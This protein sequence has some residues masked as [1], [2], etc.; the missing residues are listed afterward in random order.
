MSVQ[1]TRQPGPASYSQPDQSLV[2]PPPLNAG[3]RLS[4]AE[5]ERRHN[6]H[7]EI[8]KAELVEGV[9]YVPSP[10]RFQQHGHPQ[11]NLIGWLSAYCAAT[12]GVLA[13]DNATVRLDFENEVQPD[14][15][16]RLDSALGGHSRITEDDDVEGPPELI[17]EIAA[18]SAAYDLHDKRRVYAR[19]GVQ[20]Y[21]TAQMYEQHLDWFILREGVYESLSPDD[22]GILHS[23]VFPGLWLPTAAFWDGDL[24]A[25]IAGVQQGLAASEHAAF[26]AQLLELKTDE[27]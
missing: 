14:I 5:F 25:M 11:F 10:V 1:T 18:S 26:V 19:T 21:L 8:K 2:E 23:Q 27:S 17:V 24:A 9:V 20:E 13:A 15:Q 16:V 12:P 4:R 22:N 7:P 6:A 3:D